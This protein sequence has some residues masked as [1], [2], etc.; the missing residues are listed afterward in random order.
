MPEIRNAILNYGYNIRSLIQVLDSGPDSLEAEIASKIDPLVSATLVNLIRHDAEN[1]VD[2]SHSLIVSRCLEQ[3]A[4]G[5]DKYLS[6]DVLHSAIASPTV[7]RLL[8][9]IRGRKV[10]SEQTNILELFR[11]IPEM[12]SSA[13]WLWESLCHSIISKGGK[14]TL[15][16]MDEIDKALVP[17]DRTTILSLERLEPLYFT[18]SDSLKFTS[19]LHN[20]FVPTYGNNPTFDSFFHLQSVG[21]GFQM[22]LGR[23]HTLNPKGL[24]MLNGRLGALDKANE[25]KREK[26]FVFVIREGSS[27]R[28]AKPS[29]LQMKRFKFFTLELEP[30]NSEHLLSSPTGMSLDNLDFAAIPLEVF[31]EA[32]EMNRNGPLELPQDDVMD[33]NQDEEMSE[34]MN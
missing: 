19:G 7:W 20:Y 32:V 30:P 16:G 6:G 24:R 18:S 15:R 11:K 2:M 26:W 13:G 5:T 10:Y 28:C 22:T 9:N 33:D 12:A 34:D 1:S 17:S 3:P 8:L 23:T 29:A 21:V 14:F 31:E 25:P 4:P 27:F